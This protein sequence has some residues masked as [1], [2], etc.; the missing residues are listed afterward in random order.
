M[1]LLLIRKFSHFEN[2]WGLMWVRMMWKTL[3]NLTVGRLPLRIC[4]NCSAALNI[5]VGRRNKT[6]I[7]PCPLLRPKNF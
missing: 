7:T 3:F 4:K 6:K 5:T 2:Q 1:L